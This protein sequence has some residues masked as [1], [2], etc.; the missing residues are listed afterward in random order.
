MELFFL[1]IKLNL[2]ETQLE[3]F[4]CNYR[5]SLRITGVNENLIPRFCVIL[6]SISSGFELNA[7]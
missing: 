4:F 3:V 1:V 7:E 6:Q 5:E 2:T